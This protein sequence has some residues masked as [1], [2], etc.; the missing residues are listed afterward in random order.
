MFSE[1]EYIV[2]IPENTT[3]NST[4]VNVSC[5]ESNTNG[6]SSQ[7]EITLLPGNNTSLFTFEDGSRVVLI[8]KLDFESLPDRNNPVYY[9]QLLCT[10]HYN[11]S[12]MARVVITIVNVD[13]NQFLFSNDSYTFAIPENTMNSTIILNVSASDHDEP[14][15]IISYFI[16]NQVNATP[17]GIDEF[18][19]EIFVANEIALDRE[20]QEEYTLIIRAAIVNNSDTFYA[21]TEVHI[22]LLDIND[23]NPWFDRDWYRTPEISTRNM[24]GEYLITVHATDGDLGEN[25]T[26]MYHLGANDFLRINESTGDVYINSSSL[27]FG[28]F[29][30]PVYAVDGGEPPRNGSAIIFIFIHP[31][32]E[33]VEFTNG[34]T[35]FEF[36]VQEDHLQGSLI[37][38]IEANI[39]DENNTII[40]MADKVSYSIINST[41]M[42]EPFYISRTTGELYLLS[43]LDHEDI[44]MYLLTI[45]AI[46]VSDPLIHSA[47]ATVQIIVTD[48]ND[49][50]PVFIP[51]FYATVVEEFTSAGTSVLTISA[52]DRDILAGGSGSITY[53]LQNSSCGLFQINETSGVLTAQTD[54]NTPRDC[55][56]YAIASDGMMTSQAV[57]FISI[58]RSASVTPVFTRDSYNFTIPENTLVGRNVGMVEALTRENR[59]IEE[60]PHLLYQIRM[61]DLMDAGSGDGALFH[62]D[63]TSG[64]IS[65]LVPFDAESQN[66]YAFFVEVYNASDRSQIFDSA[67]VEVVI[68]DENDNHPVFVQTLYTRVITTAEQP[69]SIILTVNATDDDSGINGEILY[70]LSPNNTFHIDF[71]S[72]AITV[73]TFPLEVDTHR[74]IVT[75]ADRGSPTQSGTAT[76]FIAIIPATPE[77]IRFTEEEYFFTVRED[78]NV[79][80][81][82]G[83]V[84]AVDHLN[85]SRGDI[86]Y[87]TP[88]I[89]DC[90]HINPLH[91]EIRVACALNRE[92]GA[93]YELV[94]VANFTQT[95]I[96]SLVKVVI[97][98]LDINDESPR[99]SQDIYARLIREDFGNES[100]VVMVEAI[101][102]DAGQ[103]G[104]VKYFFQENNNGTAE[105]T[106]HFRINNTTGEIFLSEATVP[107]GNYKLTVVAT[108]LGIPER[109]TATALVL[110]RVTRAPPGPTLNFT[111]IQFYVPEDE[112]AGTTV[113][114]VTLQTSSGMVINPATY[115]DNLQ[116]SI[117]GGDT[118]DLFNIVS[119]N[120]T[121]RTLTS[122][123]RERAP[124]HIVEVLAV[125]S[126]FHF[127]YSTT[128]S[129][130]VT[131]KNDNDPSFVPSVYTAVIDDSYESNITIV[132]ISAQDLDV[133]RNRE[134]DFT[135]E[136]NTPFGVSVTTVSQTVTLGEIFVAN[137]SILRPSVY[138]FT[139]TA[140]DNGTNPLSGTAQVLVIVNHA[141]PNSI[142]FSPDR[143]NFSLIENSSPGTFVGSVSVKKMT[144]ALDNLIYRISGGTGST[145]FYCD[146]S[147]G[148]ITSLIPID[149]ETYPELNLTITAFLPGEHNLLPA[150][151]QVSINI[152]DL[153][154][155]QPF[156]D[157]PFY[158]LRTFTSNITASK[159]LLTVLAFD[160]DEGSN[161]QLHYN[162]SERTSQFNIS[163]TGDIFA[164]S[165]NLSAG[166]YHLMVTA[167]D[168]GT[169]PLSGSATVIITVREPIPSSIHFTAALY[170]FN[171]SEYTTPGSRIGHVTL[172][173]IPQEFQQFVT[174]ET[175]SS[176]FSVIS[177]TGEVRTLI[178]LD[179]ELQQNYTFT[180]EAH[181]RIPNENPPVSLTDTTTVNVDII[182]ENDNT[183]VFVDFP[184]TLSFPEN[185]SSTELVHTIVA[186]DA[187]SGSNSLLCYEIMNIPST[188]FILNSSSGQ[189][190]VAASLDREVQEEY[191][192]I[193][194]VSDMGI[195]QHSR[196]GIITFTLL[197][198]N[199]NPPALTSGLVYRVR[200]R[201]QPTATFNLT[202][203]DSDTGGLGNVRYTFQ[204]NTYGL[205]S[206]NES[207]G[208]V[209]VQELDYE[210]N[211]MY[212]LNLSLSDNWNPHNSTYRTNTVEQIITIEVIDAPDS[213]PVFTLPAGQSS[214]Q[215][216][217]DPRV[218]Q[219]ETMVTV[220]AQDADGDHVRYSIT[221]TRVQGNN[222]NH[223]SFDIDSTTGRIYSTTP[224]TFIPES[225]FNLTVQAQDDSEFN[226][227]STVQVLVSVVPES[228]QF[229]Q[230]TYTVN[231]AENLTVS[232]TVTTLSI[233][234]LSR[235]SNIQYS[236]TVTQPANSANTFRSIGVML[237]QF[238]SA[239]RIILNSPLDREL[240]DSYTVQV[241]ATRTGPSETAT[242]TLTVN[243]G[244]INDNTPRF[245]DSMD[246]VIFVREN[247][248]ASTVISR[249]NATD[250]DIGLNG[251]IQYVIVNSLL[252]LPFRINGTS[253]EIRVVGNI[254]YE[255]R[256]MFILR[257]Q[258]SD[259][260]NPSLSANHD[261][262]VNVT[263]VNDNYPQF[264]APA[265][266]GE[267]YAGAPDNY[268]VHHIVLRVSDSDDPY[269]MQQISFQI[270]IPPITGT[271][272]TGY[273]LQVSDR[274]PYYV[275]AVSI[276][277]SAQS[278]L[279]E[280]VIEVTDEGGLSSSV[281]LYLSIFTAENLICFIL[282]GVDIQDFLS[283]T[284]R[285]TSLCEFRVAVTEFIG[286]LPSINGLVSFYNDSV[287]VSPED[288]QTYVCVTIVFA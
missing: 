75:A 228:L 142:S 205:F 36:V 95:A 157:P 176:N 171:T 240:V 221:S 211:H 274:E 198:I 18:R 156:F 281:P 120:G 261:Y 5:A 166:T 22:T 184:T 257:V 105:A 203:T 273:N 85:M 89:T 164:S 104:T 135:I 233:Q 134:L 196:E 259:S 20:Q 121:I 150:T 99:F 188:E 167:T 238:Q 42:S 271:E 140:T 102:Q 268:R 47:T 216:S 209:T 131:D 69:G 190:F 267:V 9:L 39:I 269:N 270:S 255:M 77:T 149:R 187:D 126:E 285:R 15:A 119:N 61:P 12:T 6:S 260:G 213:V 264:A 170:H 125:F 123:D 110:I 87:S 252:T 179:Y 242:T 79:S 3:V 162:I 138:T 50:P 30:V 161:Q 248:P 14:S 193:V 148:N 29:T 141:I 26:V 225:V 56:F 86:V 217:T 136:P 58:V 254:D 49:N 37:G 144:P 82:V 55:R 185:R 265:Y 186:T 57:V 90:L 100:A 41:S 208:V 279:L 27:G 115:S 84:Q 48:V 210:R 38:R 165:V 280:F 132:N 96:V 183:P 207:T 59:S 177:S 64:N 98:V 145:M 129:I 234:P 237:G 215:N 262:T 275:V 76:V 65:A 283:C 197:D 278:Q 253:G 243:I 227:T 23:E 195:P 189:L 66:S 112:P 239:V 73:G 256:Q 219:N 143:Y 169:P 71:Q 51:E 17:F 109:Q 168:M 152:L 226:L 101:D 232:S 194:Q 60:Y 127:N 250:A 92:T 122:L 266:F 133:G 199:D 249:V 113:G 230:S 218:T 155:N 46:V 107:A 206:V 146:P 13:D 139:I 34:S 72:G 94:V 97:D 246:A 63:S 222:G 163:Q 4:I 180:V 62:I 192:L 103:N 276:P 231:I 178:H 52:T 181:L 31:S 68:L 147:T 114:T 16:V 40:D 204:P 44:Q 286:G 224:Q 201:I 11:L 111:R 33:R 25:G 263:N 81:L 182:D 19:G 229:T 160:I 93:G 241:T 258:I 175:A 282:D 53:H 220:S 137:T 277:D 251:Q 35:S 118:M 128:I 247:T 214:Y 83:R 172:V 236:I 43:I 130:E 21:Q 28:S 70:Y 67:S 116:F 151:T 223:P 24:T 1:T 191:I 117:T 91:G 284:N 235:S 106:D 174:Y 54:L 200:E 158:T 202:S 173:P 245:I 154:D 287:Q 159:K 80:T 244:D 108:D 8:Q 78:A 88:N 124:T 212:R 32:P 45:E 2:H 74:L 10:N 288:T 272:I 153:N 7:V